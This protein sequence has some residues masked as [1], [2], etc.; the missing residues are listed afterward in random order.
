MSKLFIAEL[1]ISCVIYSVTI[2][3]YEGT[4]SAY[5]SSFFDE[6]EE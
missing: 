2:S 6:D 1:K 3:D 4:D 5:V